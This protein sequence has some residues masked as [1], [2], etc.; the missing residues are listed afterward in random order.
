MASGAYIYNERR[1]I[2]A[3]INLLAYADETYVASQ[4]TDT[5]V[6]DEEVLNF[7]RIYYPDDFDTVQILAQAVTSQIEQ[8]LG[9][10]VRSKTRVAFYSRPRSMRLSLPYGPHGAIS[11]VVGISE[12]GTETTIA[13]ASYYT[14]GAQFK[15]IDL[16]D[17]NYYPF[18][19]VTFASGYS[20]AGLPKQ[21]ENAILQEVAY[22]YKNRSDPDTPNRITMEGLTEQAL[23]LLYPLK[24]RVF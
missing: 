18:Y 2:T 10:D 22:Q 5:I 4:S 13:A 11:S 7:L 21:I 12:D 3:D 23:N 8:Y 24:K 14:Q 6:P 9:F 15:V 17:T 16:R 20:S 19:R 1:G